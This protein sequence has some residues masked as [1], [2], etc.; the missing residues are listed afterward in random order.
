VLSEVPMRCPVAIMD[1]RMC[2]A[3]RITMSRGRMSPSV[4]L[5]S[6]RVAAVC[7]CQGRC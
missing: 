4:V 7:P 3:W 1:A 5:A 2:S 6:P